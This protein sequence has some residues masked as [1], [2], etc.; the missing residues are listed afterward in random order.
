ML[1]FKIKIGAKRDEEGLSSRTK[2]DH[3][4]SV[5]TGTCDTYESHL[6]RSMM[7]SVGNAPVLGF[8]PTVF[9]RL[10]IRFLH[11]FHFHPSCHCTN[12]KCFYFR[13]FHHIYSFG[14]HRCV[15]R[16]PAPVQNSHLS[17]ICPRT[18]VTLVISRRADETEKHNLRA[19]Q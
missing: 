12:Q 11:L 5:K 17:P 13:K 10:E 6:G 15:T 18:D 1:K 9:T 7:R 14:F 16:P 8:F 19:A 4:T 3:K 2:S